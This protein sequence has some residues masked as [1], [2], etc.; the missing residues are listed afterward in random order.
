MNSPLGILFVT[1]LLDLIGF[2]IIL[3][4]LP[5]YARSLGASEL[6]IG[7]IAASFSV[8]T[9]LF[10]P[11][12]GRWSD[13]IGRRPV[14]LACILLNA[15]G[16]ALFANAT[17][18]MLLVLSRM[19]NGI[20]ASNIS[21]AQ[22]YIADTTSGSDRARSLGLIGAAFGIGFIIGPA[23]GGFLKAHVGL[24]A[25]GYVPSLL[26]LL[27]AL[28]AWIRLP[29]P[30]RHAAPQAR[31]SFVES[32]RTAAAHPVRGRL[33]LLSFAYWLAFVMM[34]ISFALFANERYGWREDAIGGVF[35]LVGIIGAG[36]QGGAI[37]PLV[38][39]YGETSLLKAGLVCFSIGMT[40]LPWMP[41]PIPVLAI[42]ALMAAGSALVNP[43]MNALLSQSADPS[44]QGAVL[45]LSQ[46][47]ASLARIVGP[48]VGMT[49][50]GIRHELP[51]LAAGA[52]G[53]ACLVGLVLPL[54]APS[55]SAA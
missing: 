20:G 3:P 7:L 2:G 51:Y 27:N 54:S 45:G 22:A 18:L 49:L 36:I 25:V 52:I 6:G 43:T 37:G 35:A 38:R 24:A 9:F 47:A 53:V 30:P 34:Q 5:L 8:M 48:I 39:R 50:Y 55:S 29:E 26:S 16:Y 46:S 21:V 4:V 41:A 17:T 10:S 23:L 40:A 13:R 44:G 14:L 11:I 42:L 33:V 28:A 31:A 19:L 32:I 1:V 15:A 12:L